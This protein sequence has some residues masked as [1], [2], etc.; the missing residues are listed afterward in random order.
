ME[1]LLD[2]FPIFEANQV[3]SHS[4]LNQVRSYLDEQERLTRAN[5]IGIGIVC[6]LEINLD[7][8]TSTIHL[9]KGCGVTSEGYLIVEPQDV[10]LVSYREYILPSELD[11]APFKDAVATGH[12]Q[13]PLWEIFPAGEPGTTQLSTPANFLDDKAVLLFLELKKEDLRN[14]SPNDCNDRG[15]ELTATVRRLLIRTDDLKAIIAAANTLGSALTFTD[16]ESALLARLNLP[17][18][19]LQRY[20]I[21]NTGPVTSNQVLAAFHAVFRSEK[22]ASTTSVALTAAYDAFKP[23]LESKYP[24]NPFAGFSAE[25]G[26]LDEAPTTTVQVQ[27]LQYYYDFF[28]D[29]TNAY[30]E[31]RWKGV[32]LLCACCPPGD[33]FPRHLMLGV[34]FPQTIAQPS[35]YRHQFLASPAT[36]GCEELRKEV[37]LLFQ[38]LVEMITHFT[39]TPPLTSFFVESNIDGQIQLTP[40]KLRD[41]P[42]SD[43]AIPYYYRQD[44]DPPLYQV[45]NAEKSRRNRANQNLSYR[46]NEYIPVAPAFVLNPLRYDL[47]PHNFL[48]I[49]GHLGKPYRDVLATLLFL[50]T[51]YRLPIDIIALR[52]GAFDENMPVDLSRDEAQV[53]DL[54]ALYDAL[55]EELLCTLCEG[56]RY[57]YSITAGLNTSDFPG[58]TPQLPLLQRYAPNFR[59]VAGSVG[60]WYERYLDQIQAIPYIDIDQNRVPNEIL[61]VYCTLFVSTDAPDPEHF[62]PIVAIYYLTKLA[63]I[64]PDT[65]DDLGYDNFENRYQDLVGLIRFL[66]SEAVQEISTDLAEFIPQEDLIDYFDHILF[67]CKFEPIKATHE[68]FIRRI[69]EVK[70][71]QFLSFF[72]QDHPGIQHK[73]GVPLGGTF[74]LVYH[75][76]PPAAFAS[77]GATT[78]GVRERTR[79]GHAEFNEAAFREAFGRIGATRELIEN[80]DIRFI[81]G[82]LTGE[83]PDR[84]IVSAPVTGSEA[85]RIINETVNGLADGTVIADFF[86]PYLCCGGGRSVQYVLP[87]PS[88]GLTVDLGCTNPSGA[89]EVTLTPQGG[90]PPITYQLD[91]QPFRPLTG[92]LLLSVEPHTIVIRDSAGAES[93][94]RSITVPPPLTIGPETYTDNVSEGTYTVSFNISGGTPPYSVAPGTIT[95][96]RFTSPPVTSGAT[97][98]VTITDSVSCAITRSFQHT[99]AVPCTLP[100]GG[101]SRRCAYRL[102]LQQ[103]FEGDLYETYARRDIIRFR[104]NDEDIEIPNANDHLRIPTAELNADFQ[105]AVGAAVKALNDAVNEALIAKF[106]DD[107]NNRLVITY[108]PRTSDPFDLLWIE[109]FVCETFNI[110][111]NYSF[112]KPT[113]TFTLVMRYTNEPDPEGAPFDGAILINRRLNNQETRTPA[114]DCSERNQ[115][116]ETPYEP[117]CPGDII[118]PRITF[119]QIEN[120]LLRFKGSVDD[121]DSGDITAWVWEVFIAQPS[122]PFYVGEEVEAQV[123]TPVGPV[124][125]TAITKEGCFG[126][127]I[128][129]IG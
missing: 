34:L 79:F 27:F 18:L 88:L 76:E 121:R 105:G 15:A 45:W 42:L 8:A 60:A 37:E 99:V 129:N 106:G 51:R 74:I 110:E 53:Q 128:E 35:L 114:F 93:A 96:A 49:E 33:L 103:P 55:R 64:L 6:G 44:G 39:D 36:S 85:D 104:F 2:T 17:D 115:C 61:R 72:L 22:L 5:L 75:E 14:C 119:E 111:F 112:A 90:L 31:F 30:D 58:G 52:T 82:A 118:Q 101:Q 92:P 63:E 116:D 71:K 97:I 125:L 70:Q 108:E 66:R 56:V 28:D 117:L 67:S 100:C 83:I 11:Y 73:A 38:R 20:D 7:V 91:N 95:G 59:H 23:L 50:K 126:V 122:E 86:L 21:P 10:E 68:E 40:S 80:P 12:P 9:S 120:N 107:G 124:R 84:A 65:L 98:D 26:F 16:L 102:W 127:A 3:L 24:T 43:K 46:S 87:L 4:H 62:A 81:L 123:T 25:F 32:E 57:L 1:I 113:P 89:A 77:A 29:L 54:E 94:P 48:R 19:R 47:E 41:V 78:S 13:Y 69:R 109:Y